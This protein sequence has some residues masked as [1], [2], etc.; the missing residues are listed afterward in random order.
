MITTHVF[1]ATSLDGFIARQDG[2]IEWLLQRDDP[3][4][5]HGYDAFIADKDMIVMGRG[6][7]ETVLTFDSWPYDL[8][9]MVLSRQLANEPVPLP[10][11]GK[12]QFS[13]LT[14]KQLIKQ[15]GEQNVRR[16]YL[17]G[18]QLIQ[19]FLR[20]NLVTEMVITTVPV[21]LGSGRPLFGAMPQDTDF[22][23]LSSQSFPSGLVQSH[24]QLLQ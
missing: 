13:N 4:E 2:D 19:S 23:L 11:E 10:L 3:A 8:P 22:K 5:D 21:L 17:D 20:E 12:V 24:Y 15:L 16:V 6:T 7:Y 14:P 18:G 9:V 1:I